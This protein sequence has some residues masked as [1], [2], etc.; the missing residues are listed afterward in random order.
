MN[1]TVTGL[2]SGEIVDY[3][4]D[5]TNN[6]AVLSIEYSNINF[7]G[8]ADFTY[9]QSCR[10]PKTVR[11]TTAELYPSFIITTYFYDLENLSF[12]NSYSVANITELPTI[13]LGPCVTNSKDP[14]IQTFYSGF[15]ENTAAG[16]SEAFQ[17]RSPTIQKYFISKNI[18]NYI[19]KD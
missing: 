2:N 8:I 5:T 17:T 13:V 1:A 16:V 9:Y 10:E 4:V 7:T 11:A 19:K 14:A 18:C 12:E 3:I 6:I 15:L